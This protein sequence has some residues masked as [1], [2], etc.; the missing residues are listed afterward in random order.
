MSPGARAASKE[1]IFLEVVGTAISGA[2]ERL[3]AI[4]AEAASPA[5][6][7]RKA[8]AGHLA[9]NLN[10]EE[11]GYYAMLVINDL[12]RTSDEVRKEIRGLQRTYVRRFASVIQRGIDETVFEPV[13]A[14]VA[15][16]AILNTINYASDWYRPEGRMSRQQVIDQLTQQLLYGVLRRETSPRPAN[17]AD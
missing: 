15:T 10:P 3:E 4:I 7:L 8:I 11:E 14:H 16:L 13:N 9:Y 6:T 17:P 5:E 1:E 2:L 12:R